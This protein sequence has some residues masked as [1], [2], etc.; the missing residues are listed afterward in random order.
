ME[1]RWSQENFRHIVVHHIFKDFFFLRPFYYVNVNTAF[2]QN[3]Y[4]K[5][6]VTK[7]Y[8]SLL[9]TRQKSVWKNGQ[10]SSNLRSQ[11]GPVIHFK[12]KLFEQVFLHS[13]FYEFDSLFY[14]LQSEPRGSCWGMLLHLFYDVFII[15]YHAIESPFIFLSSLYLIFCCDIANKTMYQPSFTKCKKS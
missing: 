12:L 9:H 2:L 3:V 13:L 4:R 11:Q 1:A 7:I 5:E 6:Q 14:S 8:C 10:L 15:Q